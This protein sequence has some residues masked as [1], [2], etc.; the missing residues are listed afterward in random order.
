MPG[1]GRHPAQLLRDP[2]L[3]HGVVLLPQ[4]DRP[5]RDPVKKASATGRS[6][7]GCD[8]AV[9]T[10]RASH[11]ASGGLLWNPAAGVRLARPESTPLPLQCSPPPGPRSQPPWSPRNC[12]STARTNARRFHPT[13]ASPP[14]LRIAGPSRGYY[15]LCYYKVWSWSPSGLP[16]PPQYRGQE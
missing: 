7:G 5:A 9:M 16:L 2:G 8:R 11:P 12:L 6:P 10:Q 14:I 1:S 3:S 15:P 13:R 4:L